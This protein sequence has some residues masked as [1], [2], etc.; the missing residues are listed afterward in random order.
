MQQPA[1]RNGKENRNGAKPALAKAFW[2]STP[3]RKR[4][5][6]SDLAK[7]GDW[8][9]IVFY[10]RENEEVQGFGISLLAKNAQKLAEF[11]T[12]EDAE[13]GH[14]TRKVYH[15]DADRVFEFIA[16]ES[17]D[18]ETGRMAVGELMLGGWYPKVAEAAA[19]GMSPSVSMYALEQ[20]SAIGA[21]ELIRQVAEHPETAVMVRGRAKGMLGEMEANDLE[22]GGH[23][24]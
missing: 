15:E 22:S 20:L 24:C 3:E 16:M 6:L 14:R 11:K 5:Y 17:T 4:E 8:M 12:K 21:K 1:V 13:A 7:N 10:C 18:K 19:R 23:G 2:E 9:G